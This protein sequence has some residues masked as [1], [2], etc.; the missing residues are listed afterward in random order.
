MIYVS[1]LYPKH[2]EIVSSSKLSSSSKY[3]SGKDLRI[4][5]VILSYHVDLS[6][7]SD[8]ADSNTYALY[9]HNQTKLYLAESKLGNYLPPFRRDGIISPCNMFRYL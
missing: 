1:H 3:R 4:L 9:N 7:H 5:E 6:K 8:T 2:H